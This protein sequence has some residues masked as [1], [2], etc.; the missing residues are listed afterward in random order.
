[1]LAK[2]ETLSVIDSH[3]EGRE[4]AIREHYSS[5]LLEITKQLQLSDSRILDMSAEVCYYCIDLWLDYPNIEFFEIIITM[6]IKIGLW[7]FSQ[8]SCV[9][10]LRPETPISIFLIGLIRNAN[11]C[12]T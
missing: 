11:F 3:E 2:V 8:V 12:S 10:T 7:V 1:M 6:A 9:R 5:K 4:D